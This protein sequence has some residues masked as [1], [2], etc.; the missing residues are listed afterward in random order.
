M[1]KFQTDFI[2]YYFQQFKMKSDCCILFLRC[3]KKNGN[4][5][6]YSTFS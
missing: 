2:L 1:E 4:I 5:F 3:K 6:D